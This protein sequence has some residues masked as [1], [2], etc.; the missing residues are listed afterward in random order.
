MS[1]G[2]VRPESPVLVTGANGF[3]GRAL[4]AG[5]RRA[6]CEVRGAILEGTDGRPL[7]E[8]GVA[9]YPGDILRPASLEP[10]LRGVCAVYH[11]AALATDWAPWARFMRVNAAGTARVLE[12]ARR[13]GVQRL[14][15]MSSLVVHPFCGHVAADETASLGNSTNG[16]CVAKV[17]AEG[18]VR[19]AQ[20]RGWFDTV[21]IRPAAIIYGPGDTTA[22]IHLAPALERGPLPLVAGGEPLTCCIYVG[23]LVDGLLLAG[24]RPAAAGRT[25]V[26]T[27]DRMLTWRAYLAAVCG[28]LGTEPRFVSVPAWLA[29]AAGWSLEAIWR[30]ARI[31]R[32]PVVHRYRVGLTARDFHFGCARAKRELGY[33]PRVDLETGLQRTVAWYR[34][35][36]RGRSGG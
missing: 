13:A 32:A 34:R 30:T 4:C 25:Y 6:G 16:Y 31:E 15:H 19:R 20:A 27:D 10:A 2:T 8:L 22:F 14:I 24:A 36:Q 23:N 1:P 5:L 11:L 33:R 18:H 17:V 9:V 12:A 26:L 7:E 28:A 29:R 3:I 21:I 35:W